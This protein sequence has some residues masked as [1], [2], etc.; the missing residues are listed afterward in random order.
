MAFREGYHD[1]LI[2]KGGL[3]VFPRVIA[4]DHR[5]EVRRQPVSSGNQGFDD[6]LGGGLDRGTTT[7]ILGPAGTGKSTLAMQYAAQMASTGER[8]ML[9]AFDE[10]R[11]L[12]LSRGDALG[13]EFSKQVESGRIT[14]QQVDPAEIS[15]GEFAHRVREGV[16]AGFKLV[17]IDSLNGYLNAMPGDRYLNNQLH[18]LSA[19][20]NQQGVV[21]IFILAQHGLVGAAESS[22]E[23][24]YL[25]D[26]VV[27]VRFFEA[28]GSVKVAISVLKK[29][30]GH[31]ESTIREFKLETG[32]G[33]RIG[34]PLEQFH[35]VLTGTPMFHGRPEEIMEQSD[36]KR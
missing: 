7:M 10:V 16:D 5:A 2:D 1:Y 26:T 15:P 6:L 21:T 8:A 20:L 14:V 33:L 36:G 25:A 35:G 17:V 13:M 28:A 4:A 3:R 30:S 9:F 32:R 18:E 31:H 24:T 19:Y 12:V 23:L 27:S 22:M 11:G 29:R 34:P